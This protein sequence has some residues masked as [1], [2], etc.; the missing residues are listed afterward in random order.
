M[1]VPGMNPKSPNC[2]GHLINLV[3]H[4]G[5]KKVLGGCGGH[6]NLLSECVDLGCDKVISKHNLLEGLCTSHYDLT[7]AEDACCDLLARLAVRAELDLDGRVPIG[8]EGH[9]EGGVLPENLG[10]CHEVDGIVYAEV[11]VYHDNLEVFGRDGADLEDSDK[12]LVEHADNPVA[13]KEVGAPSHLYAAVGK[14]LDGLCAVVIGVV[15]G[16]LVVESRDLA[17]PLEGSSILHTNKDR[18]RRIKDCLELL[19]VDVGLKG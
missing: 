16:N 3:T 6:G 9:R 15:K 12:Q 2:L 7:S 14:N 17:L 19:D 1:V 8:V 4:K 11:G 10:D 13:V 5:V 18:S